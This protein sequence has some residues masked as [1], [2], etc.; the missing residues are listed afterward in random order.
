MVA[1]VL[2]VLRSKSVLWSYH[3]E[4]ADDVLGHRTEGVRHLELARLDQLECVIL[5]LPFEGDI[6]SEHLE[7]DD[8][9]GPQVTRVAVL[10]SRD[11]L[12][13]DVVLGANNVLEVQRIS[14]LSL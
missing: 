3:Q 14:L 4:V 13:R 5:G 6:T 12:R 7:D 1:Q 10:P 11:H 8:A 2:D 9:E